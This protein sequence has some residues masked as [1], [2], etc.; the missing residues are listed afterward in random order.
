[1]LANNE[2]L[3]DPIQPLHFTRG[4]IWTPLFLLGA[5]LLVDTLRGF[6]ARSGVVP[7]LSAAALCGLMLFD[8]AFWF[9]LIASLHPGIYLS[10]DERALF[11][12][13]SQRGSKGELILANADLA[14]AA[15]AYTPLR[16]WYSHPHNTPHALQRRA[17]LLDFLESGRLPPGREATPFLI[18]RDSLRDNNPRVLPSSRDLRLVYRNGTIAA[19]RVAPAAPLNPPPP[20]SRPPGSSAR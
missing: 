10:P 8:N 17:E 11:A 2:L 5:P 20:S 12:W 6:F 14:Y 15:T 4:Y 16:A 1:V 3:I 18:V 19:W 7:K 13:L 9:G